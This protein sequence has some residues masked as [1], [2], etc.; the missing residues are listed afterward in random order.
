[1]VTGA[2]GSIG[3]ALVAA[4]KRDGETVDATD[5]DTLDVRNEDVVW[6][7]F[8]DTLPD[9][10]FHLAAAKHAPEGELDP[11]G[12]AQ[13]N[14]D[15][16]A[17]VL[18]AA[19]DCG[20]RVVMAS[21]CKACDPETAYGATKLIAERMVLNAGGSVA[22]FYNVPLTSGDVFETWRDLPA[23]EPLPVTPC[24][25]Y[26]MPLERA[27]ELLRLCSGLPSGRYSVD[28]GQLRKMSE[29]A[30]ELYPGRPQR[31]MDPR[32]G[33]RLKEPLYAA[34]ERLIPLDGGLVRIVSPHDPVVAPVMVAA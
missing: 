25:R 4:L 7:W 2:A 21:T 1:L 29:I 14:I 15:G 6:N 13:T 17:N 28:P 23:S 16:T 22:R 26:L 27:L 3:R 10:V 19:G 33:D 34:H 24:S 11:Y 8:F 9:L 18:A 31:H 30:E 20:S 32:R 5:I 12:V